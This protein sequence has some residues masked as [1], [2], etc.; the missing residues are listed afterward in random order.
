MEQQACQYGKHALASLICMGV[1]LLPACSLSIFN[2]FCLDEDDRDDEDIAINFLYIWILLFLLAASICMLAYHGWMVALLHMPGDLLKG[3][4]DFFL[5]VAHTH[6]QW[7]WVAVAFVAF[8]GFICVVIVLSYFIEEI[9]DALNDREENPS[10]ESKKNALEFYSS[11]GVNVIYVLTVGCGAYALWLYYRYFGAIDYPDVKII[12]G[13]A[14]ICIVTNAGPVPHGMCG[15]YKAAL[16]FLVITLVVSIIIFLAFPAVRIIIAAKAEKLS[17]VQW[18]LALAVMVFLWGSTLFCL[19]LFHMF[20]HKAMTLLQDAVP[21]GK[22]DFH[23]GGV[24]FFKTGYVV[25]FSIFGACVI[26]TL[27]FL[28]MAC[29]FSDDGDKKQS[30]GNAQMTTEESKSAAA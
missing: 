4:H 28:W 3:E 21:E 2:L 22:K 18:M 23:H 14:N 5:Q 20:G 11:W 29:K 6:R 8:F 15:Y 24:V 17:A 19:G 30:T 27:V 26:A 10:P 25:S 9:T 12:L 16:A 13:T 1:F 7:Y